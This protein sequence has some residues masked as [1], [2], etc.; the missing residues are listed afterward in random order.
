MATPV[1]DTRIPPPRNLR[2]QSG[3]L[4]DV[5][6]YCFGS[7]IDYG[8]RVTRNAWLDA[9]VV[10]LLVQR[11]NVIASSEQAN[12]KR[13]SFRELERCFIMIE[14]V[15]RLLSQRPPLEWTRVHRPSTEHI[16]IS[17]A[18]DTPPPLQ[19]L[20][21]SIETEEV[22]DGFGPE[23]TVSSAAQIIDA[24][25]DDA[26]TGLE[27]E[28][29]SSP[30]SDHGP[31]P[32]PPFFEDQT[33]WMHALL[34]YAWHTKNTKPLQWAIGLAVNVHR[35]FV[36]R[37][38]TGRPLHVIT[39][40]PSRHQE[41]IKENPE[42]NNEF[43]DDTLALDGL[44]TFLTLRAGARVFGMAKLERVLDAVIQD[45]MAL[46]M[47]STI[48]THP[49]AWAYHPANPVNIGVDGDPDS[50]PDHVDLWSLAKVIIVATRLTQLIFRN[51]LDEPLFYLG[52]LCRLLRAVESCFALINPQSFQQS[53]SSITT[54]SRN[55]AEQRTPYEELHFSSSLA[56]VEYIAH[57]LGQLRRPIGGFNNVDHIWDTSINIVGP[58]IHLHRVRRPARE[59]RERINHHWSKI[60]PEAR[61]SHAWTS[62][63][64]TNE[65]AYAIS[66][67]PMEFLQV[68]ADYRK[69][70][71]GA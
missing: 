35:A 40:I 33:I 14:Q 20:L 5:F 62:V 38:Q 51:D 10:I 26:M 70:D 54:D 1:V 46:V 2:N 64:Q 49:Y 65:I 69:L 13:A 15:H 11:L 55:L 56:G 25:G 50:G 12:I 24:E 66:M 57:M 63:K 42:V 36:A 53:A 31:D 48:Y 7:G 39:R 60:K 58:L 9:M 30:E 18:F 34:R 43:V 71:D 32:G 23:N 6:L 19:G 8:T 44:I 21:P 29:K 68:Y 3:G 52:L 37:D 4:L 47:R 22:C 41:G 67:D 17:I 16:D 59:M 61:E 45:F 28:H 27:P